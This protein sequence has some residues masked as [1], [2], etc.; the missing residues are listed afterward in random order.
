MVK[1]THSLLFQFISLDASMYLDHFSE[2]PTNDILMGKNTTVKI[3]VSIVKLPS[4]DG[5]D[6]DAAG[7]KRKR[8]MVF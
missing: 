8:P 2:T 4:T 6:N 3:E 5:G 1:K 7:P